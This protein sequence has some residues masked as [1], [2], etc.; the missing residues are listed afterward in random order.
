MKLNLIFTYLFVAIGSIAFA[1]YT[2]DLSS[3]RPKV[4]FDEKEYIKSSEV[5]A[6][7]VDHHDNAK[8]ETLLEEYAE[9]THTINCAR[10]YRIQVYL[11][12]SEEEVKQI[13]ERIKAIPGFETTDIYVEYQVSFR[14]KVGNYTNRLR[15][16]ADLQK[17]LKE[18]N[19]ALLL[20]ESC[21]PVDKVR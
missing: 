2:E 13:K 10:G 1:Q 14:V 11:G 6:V 21:V 19:Q 5:P 16:H 18:F 17:L 3:V 4:A 20:P 8:I 9:F 12:K 7:P 15:A